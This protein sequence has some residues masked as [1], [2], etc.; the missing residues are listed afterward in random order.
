MFPVF[1]SGAPAA[2]KPL[3]MG[4]ERAFLESRG[5]MGAPDESIDGKPC[6]VLTWELDDTAVKLWVDADSNV[7]RQISMRTP[8]VEYAIRYDVYRTDLAP[9]P[10]LFRK[11][12]G[13]EIEERR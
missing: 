1:Q 10:A 6:K 7:P 2:L 9:D 12:E 5:T 11:P 4:R 8:K 3:Q 13:V